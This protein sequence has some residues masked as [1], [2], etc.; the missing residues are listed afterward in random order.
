MYYMARRYK[1]VHQYTLNKDVLKAYY[2]SPSTL[3]KGITTHLKQLW[4]YD[5]HK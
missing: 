4:N 5:I 1:P 2:I 3:N